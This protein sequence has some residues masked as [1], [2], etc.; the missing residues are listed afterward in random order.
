MTWAD[1]VVDFSAIKIQKNENK[2]KKIQNKERQKTEA[3]LSRRRCV[4]EVALPLPPLGLLV[5]N[6]GARVGKTLRSLLKIKQCKTQQ[7]KEKRK[8]NSTNL[9][10]NRQVLE[11]D[12]G[13]QSACHLHNE[14]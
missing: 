9:S 2:A 14:K 7:T 12:C 1:A 8:E 11:S 10:S 3:D 6:S 13:S 4:V 5:P